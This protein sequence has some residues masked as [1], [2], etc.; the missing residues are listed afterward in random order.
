MNENPN[1]VHWNDPLILEKAGGQPV[2]VV[3]MLERNGQGRPSDH[4]VYQWVSRRHIPD[5]WRTPLIYCLLLENKAKLG[6]L[7]RTGDPRRTEQVRDPYPGQ[8]A[9]MGQG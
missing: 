8:L 2:G 3:A 5:R 6:E 4:A 7:F 1:A 9:R